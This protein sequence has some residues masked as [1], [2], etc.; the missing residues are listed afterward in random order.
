M[1][2]NVFL[3]DSKGGLQPLQQ[4]EFLT[5]KQL[6][7]YIEAYPELLAR[8]LSSDESE[9]RFILVETQAAIDEA[10]GASGRW[11]ADALFLDQNGVLTIVEDKRSANPEIR[12]KMVG[13]MIEYAANILETLTPDGL[14]QRLEKTQ[15]NIED[16]LAEL[17]DPSGE[18]E[19][20]LTD[21]FW[22]NVDVNLKAGKV[23][24]VFVSDHLPSE[25][26]R[27]IEFLNRYMDP[28]E[29]LGVSVERM[30][31]KTTS[32]QG[33]EVLVTSTVGMTTRKPPGRGTS[34]ARQK[35]EI[36][37][38]EFLKDCDT[39]PDQSA[40]T[41]VA[42]RVL[43]VLSE[44]DAL[45]FHCH[46]TPGGFSAC[47]VTRK[48]DGQRLLNGGAGI[49]RNRCRFDLGKKKNLAPIVKDLS[50][51]EL[52][53]EGNINDWCAESESNADQFIK[54]IKDAATRK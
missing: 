53:V 14:Q 17:L 6:D 44:C 29:V 19:E 43:K 31:D 2:S 12:R 46:R 26:R 13:Q 3:V 18:S 25:L 22:S 16:A 48:R 20:D 9:L 36:T 34:T 21:T 4:M 1:G 27:I 28:M 32:E 8:A 38:E 10:G 33:T 37:T 40:K 30:R 11:F 42:R 51:Y 15:E 39:V 52:A 7:K 45:R 47:T 50:G 24:M 5:E 49:R 35:D 41:T 23:R 54:W